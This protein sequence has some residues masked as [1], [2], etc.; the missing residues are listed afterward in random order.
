MGQI[1]N[2][3]ARKMAS[4]TLPAVAAGQPIEA[5]PNEEKGNPGKFGYIAYSPQYKAGSYFDY[6]SPELLAE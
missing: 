1:S 3:F 6:E 4:L 5:L 2:D